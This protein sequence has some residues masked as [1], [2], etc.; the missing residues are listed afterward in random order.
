MSE[1]CGLVSISFRNKN[2]DEIIALCVSAGLKYIE[3]GSDVHCPPGNI[4]LANEIYNKT[5]KAGLTT[6]CYGT[7]FRAGITDVSEFENYCITADIL[8]AE[9]IRVWA[10]NKKYSECTPEEISKIENDIDII[11]KTAKKYGLHINFEYHRGSLTE[12]IVGAKLL[13]DNLPKDI[14]KIH[15]QPNPEISVSENLKE[16]EMLPDV[17]IV[18]VF[19][20]TFE[21]GNNVRHPLFNHHSTWQEYINLARVKNPDC[22]FE[23]EF[24][25]D[26]TDNQFLEDANILFDLLSTRK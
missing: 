11:F 19:A 4:E 10:F 26:D 16:L 24:F 15:W 1:R 17:D 21:N 23:L 20:W 25:K 2:V 5:Q 12:N 18:H 9:T 22:I 8:R 6:Y 14:L 13:F 7:Y 3:W